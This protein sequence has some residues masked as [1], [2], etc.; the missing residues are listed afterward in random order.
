MAAS[1]TS[2]NS[3]FNTTNG[4]LNQA[5]LM[6]I[7]RR[8][9]SRYLG[10][11]SREELEKHTR[12]AGKTQ[13]QIAKEL[14][15]LLDVRFLIMDEMH[16]Q[17]LLTTAEL[18]EYDTE[19]HDV[20]SKINQLRRAIDDLYRYQHQAIIQLNQVFNELEQL[21][22]K[23]NLPDMHLTREDEYQNGLTTAELLNF[24]ARRL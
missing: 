5:T 6:D 20:E 4:P 23:P 24:G 7:T 1:S 13:R 10:R 21:Y 17:P 15:H 19:V 9:D 14:D 16:E 18:E 12:N 2:Q 22:P 11:L 8:H 3:A